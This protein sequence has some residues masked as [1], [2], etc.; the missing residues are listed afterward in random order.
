MMKMGGIIVVM[1]VAMM[2]MDVATSEVH[3]VVGGDHGWDPNSDI[4]SWSSGRVFRVGDQIWFAYS[5]AQGLVAELKS[6]E[7]YESC[8]MSNPIKMYTEGLHTIPLEK[9]GIRYFVSSD[10]ENCKNG[11]KLNVEVQPKDSPL[12]ALPITQTAVADGPTSPSG[13]TRYGHNVILSL[14]LCAI[15]VL[16][17]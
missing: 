12:H 3:H 8:N 1:A 16:A 14:L 9:E 11:L 7:E 4:L 10:S 2:S 15:M 17:Y 13:S 6:R 5:A